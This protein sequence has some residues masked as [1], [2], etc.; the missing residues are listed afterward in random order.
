MVPESSLNRR[1]T[2]ILLATI[3]V[4]GCSDNERVAEVAL[5]GSKRQADLDQEMIRLNREVAAGTQRLIEAQGQADQ[6]ALAAQHDLQKQRDALEL[7]R[8][9]IAEKRASE[10]L[11]APILFTLGSLTVC[12]LPIV[13]CWFLLRGLGHDAAET[14][15]SRLLI[16]QLIDDDE[17]EPGDP[18]PQPDC[19]L[20]QLNGMQKPG[21]TDSR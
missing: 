14:E 5:T 12:S 6:Q 20:G 4:I 10:S 8:R 2:L 11:L 19:K 7:E 3:G 21:I 15:V 1:A 18:S 16:D 9:Q 13:L 17:V